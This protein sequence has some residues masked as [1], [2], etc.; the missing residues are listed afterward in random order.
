MFPICCYWAFS[1]AISAL[2]VNDGIAVSSHAGAKLKFGEQYVKKGIF[3]AEQGRVFSQMATLRE[4]SDYN[5]FYQVTEEE[6]SEKLPK[7]KS[8]I[9][10]IIEKMK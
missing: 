6:M 9:K 2:F 4:K 5:S 7:V 1:Y 3:S 8:L 10:A